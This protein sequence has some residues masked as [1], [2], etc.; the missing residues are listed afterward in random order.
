MKLSLFSVSIEQEIMVLPAV[1]IQFSW[2]F[3]T[4]HFVLKFKGTAMWRCC[5]YCRRA[6]GDVN[7]ISR[8]AYRV[9]SE[10]SPGRWFSVIA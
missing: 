7:E 5:A 10:F 4:T 3:M 2:P 6:V 1:Q 8:K 9:E